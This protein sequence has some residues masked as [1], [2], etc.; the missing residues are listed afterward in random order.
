VLEGSRIVART[1]RTGVRG[2]SAGRDAVEILEGLVE[3]ERVLAGTV[4]HV[5]DGVSWRP[6]PTGGPASAPPPA[7]ALPATPTR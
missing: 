2:K 1:V 4:G 7:T 3:G 5:G 6:S